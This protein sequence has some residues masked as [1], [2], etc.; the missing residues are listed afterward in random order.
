MIDFVLR[1]TKRRQIH[2]VGHS[3]GGALFM[4][5]MATQPGLHTKIKSA[6]LMAPAMHIG[7][8][9]SELVNIGAA[10]YPGLLKVWKSRKIKLIALNDNSKMII[11]KRY[12]SVAAIK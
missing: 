1:A 10:L 6:Y 7:N 9:F 2:Y 5:A 3:M 11:I 12:V 8:S 4:M